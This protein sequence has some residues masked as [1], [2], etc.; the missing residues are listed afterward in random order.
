MNVYAIDISNPD[1][2]PTAKFGDMGKLLNLLFPLI[3]VGGALL[4][5][6]LLLLGAWTWITS[7]GSPEA[8][9][10]AQVYITYAIFGFI[11]ILASMFLVKLISYILNVGPLPF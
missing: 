3:T 10:K 2:N 1:V 11:F 7:G 8:V 6:V 9:K 4:M 5:L